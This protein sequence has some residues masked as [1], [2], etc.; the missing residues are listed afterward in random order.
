MD[1]KPTVF[2]EP[3][4]KTVPWSAGTTKKDLLHHLLDLAV[5]IPELLCHH[6][7]LVAAK[8]NRHVGKAE[9]RA[10]Q[11][12]LWKNIQ[13][14]S[15][16][17]LQW[18]KDWV[19]CYPS[20]PPRE[21]IEPQGQDEFPVFRCYDLQTKKFIAPPTLVYPD[22]RLQQTMST[23]FAMRLLLATI[24]TRPKGA[25]T[26][27]EKYQLACDIARSMEFYIRN[28]AGNMINRLA[29]P[30]RFAWDAFPPG[31]IE[32]S[33][34]SKVFLLVEQRHA[35]RLWGSSM[36]ELSSRVGFSP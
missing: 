23:Y 6:D 11:A 22:L 2:N 9:L 19:D 27:A 17:F 30:V 1:R 4:W 10:K 34:M 25:V 36:P 8:R 32:R 7:E 21:T 35:L 33:F 3:A 18:K 29:F 12:H 26:T 20:G 24:D 16:R 28:A 14:L 31:G 13:G 5:E 15:N